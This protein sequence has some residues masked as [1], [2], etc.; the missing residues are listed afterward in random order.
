M[1]D[2]AD[3]RTG[4]VFIYDTEQ[5]LLYAPTRSNAR[6]SGRILGVHDGWGMGRNQQSSQCADVRVITQFE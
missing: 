4:T 6:S 3:G 2:E 1:D 5:V